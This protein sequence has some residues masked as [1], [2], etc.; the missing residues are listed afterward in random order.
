MNTSLSSLPSPSF[1][2]LALRSGGA[3]PPAGEP[4]A[5]AA[6]AQLHAS[7][8]ACVRALDDIERDFLAALCESCG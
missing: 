6:A 5:D 4:A 7:P 8:T 1:A 2:E 3:A